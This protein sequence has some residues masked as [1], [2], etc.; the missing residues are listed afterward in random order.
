MTHSKFKVGDFVRFTAEFLD[1]LTDMSLETRMAEEVL[2]MKVTN[3]SDDPLNIY[4][5]TVRFENGEYG[6]GRESELEL[7]EED[8]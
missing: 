2:V 7:I 4:P 3:I 6:L 1:S 5:I 8:Q